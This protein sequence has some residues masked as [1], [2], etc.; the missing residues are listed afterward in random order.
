[1]SE[2][3]NN[4][5]VFDDNV[6]PDGIDHSQSNQDTLVEIAKIDRGNKREKWNK[7]FLE[8]T[9]NL[10]PTLQQSLYRKPN[11]GWQPKKDRKNRK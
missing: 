4:E 11:L 9:K 1:M 5:I 7:A 2:E 10:S 3:V 8:R 6:E